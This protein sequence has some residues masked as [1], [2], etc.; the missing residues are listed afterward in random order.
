MFLIGLLMYAS[1]SASAGIIHLLPCGVPF[2]SYGCGACHAG[3]LVDTQSRTLA[4]EMFFEDAP[5]E[6]F[7]LAQGCMD[8]EAF[9]GMSICSSDTC[10]E[11]IFFSV[12]IQL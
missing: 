8:G 9:G 3:F 6:V 11:V 4:G 7:L 12:S 2:Q 5:V 1:H 10:S